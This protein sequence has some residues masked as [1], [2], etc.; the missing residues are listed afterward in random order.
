ME[1]PHCPGALRTDGRHRPVR[2]GRCRGRGRP[3]VT[4]SAIELWRP[5]V[6]LH[7]LPF[8]SVDCFGVGR[9]QRSWKSARQRENRTHRVWQDQCRRAGLPRRFRKWRNRCCAGCGSQQSLTLDHIIPRSRGGCHHVHNLQI[10]CRDCNQA[11]GD[12][13]P[14]DLPSPATRTRIEDYR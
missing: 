3:P 14:W 4:D 1:R 2:P 11:K 13:L 8:I 5:P 7:S 10:L 9:R 6:P 12:A